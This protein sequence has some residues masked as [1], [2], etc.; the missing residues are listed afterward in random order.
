MFADVLL[1]LVGVVFYLYRLSLAIEV[2]LAPRAIYR[3]L[4]IL[5]SYNSTVPILG[6]KQH[7][8]RTQMIVTLWRHSL[9]KDFPENIL[10]FF[11][12]FN[13]IID[14]NVGTM[15]NAGYHVYI[16]SYYT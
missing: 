3:L 16:T 4:G 8:R 15:K 7:I 13:R 10:S 2:V 1:I 5:S 6:S 12:L 11:I 14:T 9:P